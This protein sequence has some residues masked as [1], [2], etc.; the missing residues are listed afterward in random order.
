MS[1]SF[2]SL[3]GKGRKMGGIIILPEEV[4]SFCDENDLDHVIRG[5]A[6]K[7]EWTTNY[8]F[9]KYKTD[10]TVMLSGNADQAD[11]FE[12]EHYDIERYKED[13]VSTIIIILYN[14]VK[15]MKGECP[16]YIVRYLNEIKNG[17]TS[18]ELVK[19]LIQQ[20]YSVLN[21]ALLE[22]KKKCG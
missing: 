8:Y 2:F 21:F 12:G 14:V 16:E 15:E 3:K 10:V 19:D 5:I 9:E 11:T 6:T 20:S 7:V 18:C 13:F 22:T 1:N 4:K 17:D